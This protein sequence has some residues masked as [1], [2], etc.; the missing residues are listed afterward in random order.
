MEKKKCKECGKSFEAK[1]A[2]SLYCSNAC[3]QKSH[4][5]RS[6][7][8]NSSENEE[9]QMNI[10]FVDEYN[11]LNWQNLDLTLFCFLR[12]NLIGNPTKD[13][14]E[15][16][17]NSMLYNEYDFD[18]NMNQ[19]RKTKAFADYQERFLSGEVKI[20]SKRESLV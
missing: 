19:I 14:I 1:R 4:Q 6:V 9:K 3:K 10:F 11:E 7:E 18:A 20:M 8:K 17:F 15:S 12:K 16:Y 13:E 5:K 2:D